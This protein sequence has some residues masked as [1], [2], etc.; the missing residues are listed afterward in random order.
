MLRMIFEA[1]RAIRLTLGHY[2]VSQVDIA[3]DAARIT[4]I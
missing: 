1:G 3:K 2:S 4:T